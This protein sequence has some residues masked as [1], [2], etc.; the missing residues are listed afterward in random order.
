MGWDGGTG[1]DRVSGMGEPTDYLMVVD[2]SVNSTKLNWIIEHDAEI[3]VMLGRRTG[4]QR[5]R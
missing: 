1:T 3:K 4:R 5:R 2:A